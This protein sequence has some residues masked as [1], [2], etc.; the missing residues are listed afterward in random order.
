[1]KKLLILAISAVL[2][3]NVNAREVKRGDCVKCKQLF[4]VEKR[5]PISRLDPVR[6]GFKEIRFVEFRK[7][8]LRRVE[9]RKGDFRKGDFHAPAHRK[10]PKR[11]MRR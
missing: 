3:A 11:N 4:M 5:A 7:G 1:M 8:N 9:L 2:V 6:K 10:G